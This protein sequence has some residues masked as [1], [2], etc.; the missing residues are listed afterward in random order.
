MEKYIIA[1]VAVFIVTV[2]VVKFVRGRGQEKKI[3]ELAEQRGWSF[4]HRDDQLLWRYPELFP[5]SEGREQTVRNLLTFTVDGNMYSSFDFTS[6]GSTTTSSNDD[7]STSTSR[8]HVVGVNLPVPLPELTIRARRRLD[9]LE[10]KL[11]KPEPIDPEFD[12]TWTVH[13]E[14]SPATMAIMSAQ[15]REFINVHDKKTRIVIQ[16][17][18]L[19]T[20]R[21]GRQTVENID[22]MIALLTGFMNRIPS[23]VWQAAQAGSYPRPVRTRSAFRVDLDQV[24]NAAKNL[25]RK[26]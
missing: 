21:S 26:E 10:N 22:E 18:V 9:A 7:D 11:T 4:A 8:Y 1:I 12:Q 23:D 25:F 14:C 17:D 24:A 20:Y 16:D 15:Q 13:G 19:F 5:L 3:A 2:M 6:T